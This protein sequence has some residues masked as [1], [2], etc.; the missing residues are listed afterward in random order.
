MK[1]AAAPEGGGQYTMDQND[2]VMFTK[3]KRPK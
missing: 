3:N 2:L 1:K